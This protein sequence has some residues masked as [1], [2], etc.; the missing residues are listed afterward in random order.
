[1]KLFLV[2]MLS[3]SHRVQIWEETKQDLATDWAVLQ[4][5]LACQNL[6]ACP[7]RDRAEEETCESCELCK[8]MHTNKETAWFLCLVLFPVSTSQGP[9]RACR[10]AQRARSL[11]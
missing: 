5:L 10:G 11:C 2:S 8:Q 6:H 9:V 4:H 7:S 3:E 1:M